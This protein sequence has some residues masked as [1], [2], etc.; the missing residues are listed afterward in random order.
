MTTNHTTSRRKPRNIPPGRCDEIIAELRA[1][2]EAMASRDHNE[3]VA[4]LV[5]SKHG[6]VRACWTTKPDDVQI[7]V[8][9]A[10]GD[11]ITPLFASPVPL[12]EGWQLVPKEPTGEMLEH[13]RLATESEGMVTSTWLRTGIYRA[14]LAA[15]SQPT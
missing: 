8:A 15:A 5:T 3:A 6:L 10:D 11:T 4:W 1:E 14:M 7:A 12:P 13:A 2:R 9:A